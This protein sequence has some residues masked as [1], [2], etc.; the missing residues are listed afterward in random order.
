MSTFDQTDLDVAAIL[1]RGRPP[2]NPRKR[3]R[4]NALV[5]GPWT[6]LGG[7]AILIVLSTLLI[8]RFATPSTMHVKSP[9]RP[10]SQV[11]AN[12]MVLTSPSAPAVRPPRMAAVPEDA[13]EAMAPLRLEP[14]LKTSHRLYA[15]STPRRYTSLLASIRSARD[16]SRARMARIDPTERFRTPS[17]SVYAQGPSAPSVTARATAP[18]GLRLR[19]RQRLA[20]ARADRTEALD[21]IWLVRQR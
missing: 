5:L 12:L 8:L 13:K 20:V 1:E 19:D 3:G 11:A 14:R 4:S 21:D 6:G 9:S 16:I 2:S 15:R 10:S 18:N 17:P 7:F